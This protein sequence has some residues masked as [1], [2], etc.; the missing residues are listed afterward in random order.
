MG[1]EDER[2]EGENKRMRVSE[3]EATDEEEENGDDED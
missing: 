1:H 2:K 3:E